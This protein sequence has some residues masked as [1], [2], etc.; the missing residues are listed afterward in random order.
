MHILPCPAQLSVEFGR[1]LR[2]S[3]FPD[4]LGASRR[5]PP[6]SLFLHPFAGCQRRAHRQGN[7]DF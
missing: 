1:K 6:F 2:Y 5:G 7:L 4:V 3:N